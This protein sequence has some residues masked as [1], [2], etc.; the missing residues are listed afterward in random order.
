MADRFDEAGDAA[1][2][3]ELAN[4]RTYLAW[5]RTGL[6]A[7]AVALGAGK[8]VPGLTDAPTAPWIVVGGGFAVLGIL[9]IA[10]SFRRHRMVERAVARGESSRP[11]EG[12]MG[13]LAAAGVVLGVAILV[14]LVVQS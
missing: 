2:R 3:T 14:F 5:W 8:L 12:V 9:L 1:R 6:T 7:F 13:F 10:Y 4:E 11:D